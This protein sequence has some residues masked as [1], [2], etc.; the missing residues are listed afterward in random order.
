MPE[1]RDE[2]VI[3]QDVYD[4]E[5][6]RLPELE[7]DPPQVEQAVDPELIQRRLLPGRNRRLPG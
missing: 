1:I 2:A 3:P 7:E 4:A 6:Q 5:E